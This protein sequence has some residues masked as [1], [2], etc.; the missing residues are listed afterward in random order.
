MKRA[1]EKTI[2]Y[3]EILKNL[4]D[5]LTCDAINK[6]INHLCISYFKKIKTIL[7]VMNYSD[8]KYEIWNKNSYNMLVFS[9]A[10]QFFT[11]K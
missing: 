2:R 10:Q 1:E 3:V 4:T 9:L 8:K 11:I 6:Y 5:L 7:L